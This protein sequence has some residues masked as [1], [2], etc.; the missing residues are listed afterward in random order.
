MKSEFSLL[1]ADDENLARRL[2]R[3]YL[4]AYPHL[5]I[6]AEASDGQQALELI[7]QHQPDLVLLD[8]QMPELNGL[9]VLEASGKQQGVVFTT[10][11]DNFALQAFNL[12][13]VDYL[14]KPYDQARFATALD[15]AIRSVQTASA[16]T[17]LQQ[18]VQQHVQQQ[19]KIILRERQQTLSLDLSEIIYVAAEDDY[20]LIHSR[21]RQF[22]KT[23]SLSDFAATLP[24]HQFIRC[25]RSF[26]VNRQHIQT[27]QKN[28]KDSQV[29]LL[30][31]GSSIAVSRSG[32][33]R[34]KHAGLLLSPGA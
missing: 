23:Q 29:L 16:A 21:Q 13:A 22:M 7:Q 25:H 31:N 12:H 27:L 24:E 5:Q 6:V 19:Q 4:R 20:I 1:L 30:S 11:Y 14:L 15:K 28:G 8:I 10:A 3:E 17:G 34:L 9:E 18:L 32:S 2:C 33:E 26:L